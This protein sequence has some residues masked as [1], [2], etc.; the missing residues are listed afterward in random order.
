MTIGPL[1][2]SALTGTSAEPAAQAWDSF[3]RSHPELRTPTAVTTLKAKPKRA[4]VYRLAGASASGASIIAKRC[5]WPIARI[6]Q[7]LYEQV[8]ARVA[9]PHL[10]FYGVVADSTPEFAWVFLEDAGDERY[11]ASDPASR[12]LAARW[13]S[14]M[15]QASRDLIGAVALPDRS[16]ASYRTQARLT[17]QAIQDSHANAAVGAAHREVLAGVSDQLESI[18]RQWAQIDAACR[19]LPFALVHGD[20]ACKNVHLRAAAHGIEFIVLDWETAGWG[21]PA[22]DLC[23][24]DGKPVRPDLGTYRS[25]VRA[26][27]HAVTKAQIDELARVGGIF[28]MITSMYW[29]ALWLSFEPVDRAM[30]CLASY[31]ECMRDRLDVGR[32]I[33]W[34]S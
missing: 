20:L 28:R 26:G 1:P 27:G 14:A 13:L 25:L 30:T 29:A 10:A 7:A 19:V 23:Q 4:G 22:V 15:H 11:R 33:V 21:V 2:A 32:R 3:R 24:L 8:L 31:H 17:R 12:R 9:L 34:A 18:E 6:E 5:R 16:P